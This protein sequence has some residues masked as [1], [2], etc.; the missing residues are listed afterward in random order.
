MKVPVKVVERFGGERSE[1]NGGQSRG[2]TKRPSLELTTRPE[3]GRVRSPST[4]SGGRLRSLMRVLEHEMRTPL[5]TSLIQLSAAEAAIDDPQTPSKAKAA[6]AAAA[7]QIRTLSLI[8]RRAV[9]IETAQPID[10]FPQR[11][12]LGQL[13]TDFMDRLRAT[14]TTVWSRVEIKVTGAVV[15]DWDPAA[16]EQILEGLLSNALKF[17][18]GR[19]VILTVAGARG[20][21]RLSVKDAGIGI[22]AKDRD[23]IFGRFARVPAALGIGGM[24]IGLWV[25]RHLIRAHGGR[26][27]VRSRPGKW[28]VIDVWLPQ[29]RV[30]PASPT[31]SSLS[32][33]LSGVA[34]A[35]T[36]LALR[37]T[38]GPV[39]KSPWPA[40]KRTRSPTL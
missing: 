37:G 3:L 24:G 12:D 25:V 13:V 21:A 14:G 8:V 32:S 35:T 34:S 16:V 28:T 29:L 27:L 19:P 31:S 18:E 39:R 36:A 7:R 2:R 23:R 1:L 40:A 11:L 26:V 33:S 9:Q 38:K 4:F 30:Y 10:L 20:G 6:L 5:A 22:E 15:G 17:G